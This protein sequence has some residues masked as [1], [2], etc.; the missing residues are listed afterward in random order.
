MNTNDVKMARSPIDDAELPDKVHGVSAQ[1]QGGSQ[2]LRRQRRFGAVQRGPRRPHWK[3]Q[4]LAEQVNREKTKTYIAVFNP[5][6][7]ERER[8]L[9][10]IP[11]LFS[12]RLSHNCMIFQTRR[13]LFALMAAPIN[14]W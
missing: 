10:F 7:T 6:E 1:V 14:V 5:Q 2:A 9:F 8:A 11:W 13:P 3:S 4:M 12:L